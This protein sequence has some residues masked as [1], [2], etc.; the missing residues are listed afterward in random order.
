MEQTDMKQTKKITW[1]W[2]NLLGGIFVIGSYVYGF[3]THS[4]ASQILW[5]GVP[6]GLRSI[7]TTCMLAAAAGFFALAYYVFR[8]DILETKVFNRFGFEIFNLLYLLVLVPSG[9]WMPL[10]L[11]TI[12][13]SSSVLI[14]MVRLD[15]VMVAAG[16][17]G[18]LLAVL[19]TWPRP[20]TPR[21]IL[22]IV[23]S[24][25]LCLQTVILDAIV[26]SIYFHG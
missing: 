1:I 24:A 9:L 23:G 10:S 6:A 19:N 12:E 26:W 2:I 22:G 18:L 21:Y 7:Y 4:N 11:L 14:W 5:G 20:S 15:L 8:L 17:L 3:L 16:S 25:A 13:S